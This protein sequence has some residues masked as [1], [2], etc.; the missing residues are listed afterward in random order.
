MGK[1]IVN[2][3]SYLLM[4]SPSELWLMLELGTQVVVGEMRPE[5]L[6][7]PARDLMSEY[8]DLAWGSGG[9]K[10][11]AVISWPV[12]E[13]MGEAE[14]MSL[15]QGEGFMWGPATSAMMLLTDTLAWTLGWPGVAIVSG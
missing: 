15:D 8:S 12:V 3:K 5:L 9:E 14:M 1:I 4:L 2:H 6:W 11:S 13:E 10:V 7:T